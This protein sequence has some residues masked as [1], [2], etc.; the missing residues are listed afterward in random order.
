MLVI[1]AE[2]LTKYYGLVHA[3]DSVS[4]DVEKDSVL[5]L[6]GPKG[7]GKTT[8]I[9]M[10]LGLTKPDR[11]EIKVFGE[12]PWNNVSPRTKI[13][14][15]HE[16]PFFPAYQTV[17]NYLKRVCRIYGVP[18][19]RANDLLVMVNLEEKATRPIRVLSKDLLQRYALAH[20]LIHDPKL[21]IADEMAV[22]LDPIARSSL[23]DL[24]LKLHKEEKVTFLLSSR[25]LPELNQVCDSIAIMNRGR[26]LTFG[27][28]QELYAKL[29]RRRES[30]EELYQ[31]FVSKEGGTTT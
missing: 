28:V 1:H 5:G 11:G 3:I 2:N 29:P 25:M 31:Q 22:D 9:K 30:L 13:G 15:I 24:V 18:E 7:A 12:N 23:F 21:V 26:I 14:V 17:L 27:K 20:A 8:L 10:I 19:S 6:I 16:K 4:L